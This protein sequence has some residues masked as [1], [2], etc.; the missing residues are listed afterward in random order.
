MALRK[1]EGAGGKRK[2]TEKNE[3]ALR[4]LTLG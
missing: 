4:P 2:G 1:P 3:R